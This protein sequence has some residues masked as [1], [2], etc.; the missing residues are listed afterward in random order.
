MGRIDYIITELTLVTMH[1][2][3]LSFWNGKG[4]IPLQAKMSSEHVYTCSYE[5]DEIKKQQKHAK[6]GES[7]PEDS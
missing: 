2:S 7:E 6:W 5:H 1:C 4:Q 3:N